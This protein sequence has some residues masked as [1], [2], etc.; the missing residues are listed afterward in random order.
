MRYSEENKQRLYEL[1][2]RDLMPEGVELPDYVKTRTDLDGWL[3]AIGFDP[4]T[5]GQR[6]ATI[7]HRLSLAVTPGINVGFTLEEITG[8]TAAD[9]EELPEGIMT[10]REL[11]E[12]LGHKLG[13]PFSSSAYKRLYARFADD[14][15]VAIREPEPQ[16]Y[17]DDDEE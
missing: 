1:C 7:K 16:F 9:I 8:G 13:L 3:E 15:P 14:L 17:D 4:V 2:K 5:D 12:Y 6:F 10:R 11:R